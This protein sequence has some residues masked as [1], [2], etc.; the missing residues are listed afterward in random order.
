MSAADRFNEFVA[1]HGGSKLDMDEDLTLQYE[2]K[3]ER[4]YYASV[5]GGPFRKVPLRVFTSQNAYREWCI[6]V[7]GIKP[8]K[9]TGEAFDNYTSTK[10]LEAVVRD[11]L[12]GNEEG[13]AVGR[14]ILYFLRIHAFGSA[15]Y[16]NLDPEHPR[17]VQE[18]DLLFFET[19]PEGNGKECF[20]RMGLSGSILGMGTRRP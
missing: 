10:L 6:A 18:G 4:V 5:Y 19:R 8:P 9:R 2:D 13:A 7:A 20:V 17:K 16:D 11:T 15:D 3:S 14:W 12:P 1:Q